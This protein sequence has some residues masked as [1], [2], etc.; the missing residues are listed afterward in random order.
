MPSTSLRKSLKRFG[1]APKKGGA[2]EDNNSSVDWAVQVLREYV[3]PELKPQVVKIANDLKAEMGNH[4]DPM[5]VRVTDAA[6]KALA[7]LNG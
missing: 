3:L 4:N 2:K 5:V 1:P 7:V 6:R